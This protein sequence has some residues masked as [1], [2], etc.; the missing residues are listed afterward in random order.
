M[1]TCHLI[2]RLW[3]MFN[4]FIHQHYVFLSLTLQHTPV[5]TLQ[6]DQHR[7]APAIRLTNDGNRVWVS[8]SQI[9]ID[10][11]EV[12]W[13]HQCHNKGRRNFLAWHNMATHSIAF[14]T[15]SSSSASPAQIVRTPNSKAIVD[16]SASAIA[17]TVNGCSQE[18]ISI[19]AN[20]TC[21]Y[22]VL[23]IIIRFTPITMVFKRNYILMG[24]GSVYVCVRHKNVRVAYST[25]RL[26]SCIKFLLWLTSHINI[27]T[28]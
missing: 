20:T 9:L 12:W 28:H 22:F 23:E 26:H 21:H 18:Y 10:K 15:P 13:K 5:H 16:G 2:Q 25:Y 27:R 24:I 3:G 19:F 6:A 17:G 11:G 1:P 7:C 14:Q 8:T 4:N